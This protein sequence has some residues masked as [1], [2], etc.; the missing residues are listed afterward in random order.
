MYDVLF[1]WI[2]ERKKTIKSIVGLV[3]DVLL[4]TLSNNNATYAR[5]K[6]A[7]KLDNALLPGW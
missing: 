2:I 1:N 6:V 4:V 3:R 5:A 7:L